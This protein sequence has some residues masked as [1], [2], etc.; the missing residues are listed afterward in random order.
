LSVDKTL[1]GDHALSGDKAITLGHPSYVWGFGQ[2]RRLA[3]IR[4]YVTLGDQA[5]L[6]VGCGLGMYVQAF[7]RFSQDVH[8]VDVDEEKVAEAGQE[9]PNLRVAPAEQ[10]PYA[11]GRFDVV[12][13]HEVIEHVEDDRQAI[14]EAGRVLR[15]GGR[16][17]IFAPN[18]LYPFET[19]GAYWG[20]T[21][22]FGNIPLVNY[23]PDRWR[24]RFCPHVRVYTRRD[25]RRLLVDLPL[26]IVVH[27]Q[28]YP[29]YDKIVGRRPR[30]GWLLRRG[31]HALERTPLRLFGLSHFVVAE[32]GL[33][34]AS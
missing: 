26:R 17:V 4:R 20:G 11:D 19:H 31:T 30:L 9:L 14:A 21:Y 16:L 32:K 1:S 34:S 10:L 22:H 6:D 18:R 15:P 33:A 8:G 25:M 3:L 13:L 23:L 27:S 5:I 28:I 12:L 7:R 24:S 2:E 29:G